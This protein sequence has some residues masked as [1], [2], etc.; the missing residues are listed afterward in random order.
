M[1]KT[2][3]HCHAPIQI[4]TAAFTEFRCGAGF[5]ESGDNW[6]CDESTRAQRIEDH[7]AFK[8]D[9]ARMDREGVTA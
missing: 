9:A 3:P 8:D 5:Y 7:D 6:E 1:S 4:E 2:C